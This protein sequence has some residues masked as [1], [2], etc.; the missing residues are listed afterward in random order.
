MFI[1]KSMHLKNQ[2][3]LSIGAYFVHIFLVQECDPSKL[4]LYIGNQEE[5]CLM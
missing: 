2:A 3:H 1:H 5:K 4:I